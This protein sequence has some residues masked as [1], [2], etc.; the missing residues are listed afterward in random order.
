ML[1]RLICH[2]ATSDTE[3]PVLRCVGSC[4]AATC[5]CNPVLDLRESL[6]SLLT[7]FNLH[8]FSQLHRIEVFVGNHAELL[9][10]CSWSICLDLEIQA[11]RQDHRLSS[12]IDTGSHSVVPDKP[13]DNDLE[14]PRSP[15]GCSRHLGARCRSLGGHPGTPSGRMS[16]RRGHAFVPGCWDSARSWPWTG[17][18]LGW[19]T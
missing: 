4:H 12:E 19:P 14:D 7:L 15:L 3:N 17:A 13:T 2:G 16:F 18:W 8:C 10:C 9:R 6:S 1:R 11:R 5:L